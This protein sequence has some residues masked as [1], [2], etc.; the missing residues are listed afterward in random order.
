MPR[1]LH[2]SKIFR[3]FASDLEDRPLHKQPPPRTNP[4][5]YSTNDTPNP[6][7]INHLYNMSKH[8]K[9][10]V[11]DALKSSIATFVDIPATRIDNR[12]KSPSGRH[13][14][15]VRYFYLSAGFDSYIGALD[16]QKLGRKY[17]KRIIARRSRFH[18]GLFQLYT[19]HFPKKWSAA[20]VANREL[21]KEAQRQAHA[22]EHAH[23]PEAL[24]WRLRFFHHYFN[25]VKGHAK[26]APGLKAYGYFF[27]YTYVCIYRE[28]QAQAQETKARQTRQSPAITNAQ[29][30]HFAED[31]T[32][33]PI[34]PKINHRSHPLPNPLS[35]TLKCPLPP[36]LFRPLYRL[37]GGDAPRWSNSR[38]TPPSGI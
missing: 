23:T 32:F 25:V 38:P 16:E 20:C 35:H 19:F 4:R 34:Y 12:R 1:N 31:V 10:Q 7:Q 28:L 14:R 6:L 3:T 27:Q 2:I 26:P 8:L 11:I 36:L 37:R 33:E 18:K 15:G 21:I 24:E 17:K 30:K 29:L 9:T 22:L 5:L 13:Y